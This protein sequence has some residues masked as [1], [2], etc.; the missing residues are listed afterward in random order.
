VVIDSLGRLARAWNVVA[1]P[2]GRALIGALDAAAITGP[3][4]VGRGPRLLERRQLTLIGTLTIDSGQRLDEVM[5]DELAETA[6]AE[7]VLGRP[8]PGAAP[9]LDRAASYSRQAEA[10]VG[11]VA[12]WHRARTARRRR[13]RA[14]A[15]TAG[16]RA[17]LIAALA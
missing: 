16:D 7:L 17:A 14:A 11:D 5:A 6:S 12:A 8:T 9:T 3:P 15:A 1:P 2:S 10:L 13:G 4:A